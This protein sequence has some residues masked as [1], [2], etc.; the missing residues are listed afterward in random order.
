MLPPHI[1]QVVDDMLPRIRALVDGRYAISIGGSIGRRRFDQYS[2]IDFR[3]FCDR[4]LSNSDDWLMMD[5]LGPAIQRWSDQGI[6]IDGCWIRKIED[7]SAKL[8]QWCQGILIP[9]D[10]VWTIWGYYLPTDINNQYVLDDPFG[11]LAGWKEQLRQYPA[12][13]KRSL[14]KKH[15]DSV[16]YWRDDY[17]YR[18]KVNRADV[19][20][21]A[22]LSSRLVHDLIQILFALNETYYIG[23]GNN[24][25]YVSQFAHAPENFAAKVEAILYPGEA[26]LEQQR[27]RLA[28]LINETEALARGLRAVE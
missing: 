24:L 20:F 5:E 22:G 6:T 16:R 13:L 3:L 9:D 19:V 12:P 11:V 26:G 28:D 7:V 1:Q 15:F 4:L 2:D 18:H 27:E 21:L 25:A 8:D 10:L 23:D 14:L 17:H